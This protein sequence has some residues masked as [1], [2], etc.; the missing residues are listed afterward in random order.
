MSRCIDSNDSRSANPETTRLMK[1][2]R[3]HGT[4]EVHVEDVDQSP[5][6]DS[7]VRIDIEVCGICGSDLHEYRAGPHFTP[8]EPHPRTGAQLP[9]TMGHELSGVVSEV[10]SAVSGVAV[11]DRVTVEPNIPCGECRYCEDGDYNLCPDS[12]AIG[13]HTGSGGFAENVVAPVDHVHT[14]PDSVSLEDGSLVEPLAV[15]LHAVRQSGLQVGDT[16]CVVGCGPIGLTVVRAAVDAGAKRIFVSEPNDAR[17][18]V[19]RELGADVAIDPI[20]EDAV[21]VITSATSGGVD[22]AFEFAGIGPAFN[23]AVQSTKRGG[24]IT[25]GSVSDDPITTDLNDVVTTERTVIG[26]NC[27]GFPPQSFRTEFDAI[28]QSLAA[29][30]IDTD[31]FVTGQ[32]ELDDIVEDGFEA[33]LDPE[34]SHVKILVKP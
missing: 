20:D 21:D 33:L 32:I 7:D 9:M 18:A 27:Y 29:G 15:G 10:G 2:A 4:E 23:T 3:F 34:T 12:V 6:G 19:A 28:I 11:G 24:T 16:A 14:L 26:T 8:E 1:A 5:L 25:V 30:D 13:F 17:R 31:P 22:V